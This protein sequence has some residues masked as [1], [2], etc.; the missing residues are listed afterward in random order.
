[1]REHGTTL[2]TIDRFHRLG[3]LVRVSRGLFA[4][5][6]FDP[7]ENHSLAEVQT[8]FASAGLAASSLE[9][10]RHDRRC[11]DF[12]HPQENW[13]SQLLEIKADWILARTLLLS[14]GE[15]ERHGQSIIP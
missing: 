8:R 3:L 11:P 2:A 6:D 4:P 10:H 5:T 7:T 9:I 14:R 12:G 1:M 15:H 13:K